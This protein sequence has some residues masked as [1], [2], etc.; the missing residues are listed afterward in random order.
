MNKNIAKE[1]DELR[2]A[3]IIDEEIAGRIEHFYAGKNVGSQSRLFVVFGVLGAILVGLGIILIIAHNWD[4]LSRP[5]KVF[6][7]FLPVI[8]G[9]LCCAYSLLKKSNSAAWKESSTSFLFF[10]V[11]ASISLV[12]QVYHIHGD[13][14]SFL[15]AWMLLCFPMIYI[16]KSSI[17][18]LLFIAGITYYQV[19]S[20]FS[21]E[22]FSHHRESLHY[23]WLLLLIVP[24][25]YKLYTENPDSN[26]LIIHNWIIPISLTISLGA[27]SRHSE[28]LIYIAY[29]SL[30]GLFYILGSSEFFNHTKRQINGYLVIGS[31]GTMH[32]LLMMSFHWFWEH[33]SSSGILLN[34]PFESREFVASVL[35]SLFAAFMYF[36]TNK[37]KKAEDFHPMK[38]VFVLFI[39]IFLIGLN[40][41]VMP[42]ILV[43]ILVLAI[44]IFTIRSGA[45][46]DH[47][48]VLNYGL[49]TITAL[50]VCRFFDSDMSFVIRGL[51][52]ML[53]GTGF[54]V[55]NYLMLK[56]RKKTE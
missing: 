50:I 24:H 51:L 23:W 43:N 28:E 11:G 14:G 16:M 3:G 2:T 56:K 55:T 42:A 25:Y 8:V 12:S 47:L 30:F 29:I 22:L 41:S 13:L 26:Y 10:A 38:I 31:L 45:K 7:S 18:S 33:L 35:L 5:V 9:Q 21:F 20:N 39:L 4:E 19:A 37:G 54:F 40:T 6:F 27:L 48:G 34:E 1:L 46:S 44:G 17:T 36:F 32:I 49:L 53:V 15:F 52:F